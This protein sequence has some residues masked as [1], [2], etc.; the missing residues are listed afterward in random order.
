MSF[1]GVYQARFKVLSGLTVQCRAQKTESRLDEWEKLKKDWKQHAVSK[2]LVSQGES[3]FFKTIKINSNFEFRRVKIKNGVE[4]EEKP[5]KNLMKQ[6]T[7]ELPLKSLDLAF[8]KA[9][10]NEV[11]AEVIWGHL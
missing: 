6:R 7:L 4:N 11:K 5:V 8:W 1:P 3:H 10:S 2:L 9:V